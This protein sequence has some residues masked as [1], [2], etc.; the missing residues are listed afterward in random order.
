MRT[1]ISFVLLSR[2]TRANVQL[3]LLS[4][5]VACGFSGFKVSR[6]FHF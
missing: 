1:V 2:W 6:R 5:V 3:Q 4:V